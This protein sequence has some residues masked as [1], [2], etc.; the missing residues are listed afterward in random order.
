M[1]T[2]LSS[3]LFLFACDAKPKFDIQLPEGYVVEATSDEYNLL[4][5]S[6]YIDDEIW[7]RVCF[8]QITQDHVIIL[9]TTS[10]Q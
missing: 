10:P 1:K 4:T 2:I 8:A 7:V 9:F 3:L 6:K 5:A